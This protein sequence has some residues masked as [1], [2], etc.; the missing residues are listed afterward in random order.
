MEI[1]PMRPLLNAVFFL[2][3]LAAAAT[4]SR[5][6]AQA[7]PSPQSSASAS[8]QSSSSP[9]P[10]TPPSPS[11]SPTQRPG[12][13]RFALDAHT[14]FISQ[15]T[16]GP[17]ISPPEAAGFANG[18]PLSPNTPY[19]LFSSAPLVPGNALES[20][21]YVRPTYAGR[22]FDASVTLGVGY[23]RGSVTNAVYW[24]ETPFATLNPHL[25]A[26]SL[27]YRVVFPTHAA[28]DD[29]TGFVA[30]VLSGTVSTKNGD[31]A[32]RAGWFDLT[33]S[34][35]FVFVQP[36]ITGALPSL[37]MAP[38]ESLGDG[39]PSLDAW[40]PSSQYLPLHGIDL[41]GKRG[42][43]T[44]ELTSAALP[45]LPG[46]PARINMASVVVDHG[47]GTK[48]S[49]Q[50]LHVATGGDLVSTT[51]VYGGDNHIESS[52][53]GPLPSSMI[54]GQ[55]QRIFGLGAAFHATKALDAV[56]ELGHSTYDADHVAEP[57]TGKA[58]NYAHLG[59]SRTVGRATVSFDLYRNEAYYAQTLLPYGAP[60]N[61]WS[62]AWSWP[63]QWLK[64]NYQLINDFPVNID[65]Q[66]YRVKYVLKGG[67]SPL[68]V[69]ASYANFGQIEPITYANALRTGFVDGFF[70]PQP[71]DAATLGRQHQYVLFAG[72]HPAFA[73]LT[74][75]YAED[76]MRRRAVLA[77]PEDTV[78]YDNPEVVITLSRKLDKNVLVSAGFARYGMRGSFGQG[79]TNVDFAQHTAFAGLQ[80]AESAHATALLTLRRSAFTGLPSR[81]GGPPPDFTGTLFV[82]EQRYRL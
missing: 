50:Y 43:A 58:G 7:S 39:P 5:V 11:P 38:L 31:L 13:V 69:R 79:Y 51:V 55:R 6:L 78:S 34:A 42:L 16:S 52:P 3:A 12:T 75:D 44:V 28:S 67:S 71:N 33:Q 22:T 35:Q 76:T 62:S 57:G 48:Y 40:Q 49:A 15:G 65:R 60:E 70:L 41:V 46:T 19:E 10:Q 37:G 23:L 64:S 29:G 8:P 45:S 18:D 80:L 66:G 27:P 54:G 9:S 30:S 1:S 72:W 61:V 2:C 25:G 56:A 47:E 20:A 68:D 32:L 53:Q 21:L 26:H 17:G 81:L 24:G 73:D 14:T 63:G 82:F 36:A 59:V 74:I 4:P 77:H